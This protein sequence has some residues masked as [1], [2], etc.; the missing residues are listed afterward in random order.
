MVTGPATEH[1]QLEA[2]NH[3]ISK[4]KEELKHSELKFEAEYKRRTFIGQ[5]LRKIID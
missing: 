1:E 5:I 4:L 2:A 3:L